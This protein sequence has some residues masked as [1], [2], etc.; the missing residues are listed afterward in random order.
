MK[1]LAPCHLWYVA[2]ATGL[3]A[4]MAVAAVRIALC[5]ILMISQALFLCHN[6]NTCI[7][8][9]CEMRIKSCL[10][11]SDLMARLR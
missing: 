6:H 3:V 2:T 7:L 11:M 10:L 1:V 4:A 9:S 5:N 8:N